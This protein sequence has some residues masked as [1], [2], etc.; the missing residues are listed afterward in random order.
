MKCWWEDILLQ[1]PEAKHF[2][3]VPFL[4]AAL[5]RCDDATHCELGSFSL[6]IQSW[7][8]C[9]ILRNLHCAG[10]EMYTGGAGQALFLGASWI[11]HAFRL[12]YSIYKYWAPST[13]QA[14]G[15]TQKTQSLWL[16]CMLWWG[17]QRVYIGIVISRDVLWK[18]RTGHWERTMGDIL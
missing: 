2:W 7:N 12:V 10:S 9:S 13:C 16:V 5:S 11:S 4:K 18:E 3:G 17:R 6:W 1:V 15:Q 14:R 8:T